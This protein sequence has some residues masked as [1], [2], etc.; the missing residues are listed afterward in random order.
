MYCFENNMDIQN[1]GLSPVSSWGSNLD[2]I[3]QGRDVNPLHNFLSPKLFLVM[4]LFAH[5]NF[6]ILK[7]WL[8]SSSWLKFAGA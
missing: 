8:E 7:Q 3:W 4:N 5:I 6:L 1:N 2:M